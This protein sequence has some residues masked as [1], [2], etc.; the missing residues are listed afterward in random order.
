MPPTKA[1]RPKTD[2][3]AKNKTA[4]KDNNG[5]GA[6]PMV[7][8]GKTDDVVREVR[9]GAVAAAEQF[10]AAGTPLVAAGDVTSAG[11]GVS[12]AGKGGRLYGAGRVE[13]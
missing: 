2:P 4:E 5:G 9:V 8:T 12:S 1:T 13:R 7:V 6:S 10:A 11:K 3:R